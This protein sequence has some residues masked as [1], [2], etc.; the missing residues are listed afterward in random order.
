MKTHGPTNGRQRRN[1]RPPKQE[2]LA[3]ILKLPAVCELIARM[4]A[5]KAT[6]RPGYSVGAKVACLFVMHLY[7]ISTITRLVE[8]VK[9]HPDVRSACGIAGPAA[10]PSVDALYRFRNKLM[11]RGQMLTL[12]SALVDAVHAR[13]PAVAHDVALDSTD[14]DA[15]CNKHRK[16]DRLR[17]KDA[18]WGVRLGPSGKHDEF[19]LGYKVH[20]LVCA[21]TETP[22]A[23]SITPGNA[24]DNL[25]AVPVFSKAQAEHEWF[26][27]EHAMMDKGYDE[28]A[29][30]EKLETVFRCHPII[31]LRDLK[32]HGIL[33]KHGKPCCEG[34]A[35]QWLGSDYRRLRSKWAC[36]MT[37]DNPKDCAGL[38]G[39]KKC[40][41]NAKEDWRKHSLIPRDTPKFIALYNKRTATEREFSRLKSEYM[42]GN[43]RVQ[44]L[45]R[46]A[47]HVELAI[48][49]RLAVALVDAQSP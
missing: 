29:L 7:N 27:P 46:V 9:G 43:L 47:L 26:A 35:W 13:N 16:K 36:P 24:S 33:D 5:E 4:E 38:D 32:P 31:P 40:Y 37:C 10:V 22:I 14:V 23:W 12:T 34:G 15:W 42:I 41:L 8:F 18:A 3:A 11:A 20:T 39:P 21:D 25:Q 30:H 19:Y 6:G 49:V 45:R 1:G 48:A 17:D 44:G 28:L 2:Q